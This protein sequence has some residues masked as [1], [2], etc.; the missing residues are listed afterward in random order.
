MI[1]YVITKVIYKYSYI[2]LVIKYNW[3][4]I[5]FDLTVTPAVTVH[6]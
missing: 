2:I 5:L 1:L 6:I 3:N 4:N